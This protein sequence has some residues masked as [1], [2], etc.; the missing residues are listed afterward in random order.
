MAYNPSADGAYLC[1]I[2]LAVLGGLQLLR[3]R[4]DDLNAEG[5]PERAE[6]NVEQRDL[7]TVD[8]RRHLL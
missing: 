6:V 8:D 2:T 3:V 4:N 1:D 7:G 5:E